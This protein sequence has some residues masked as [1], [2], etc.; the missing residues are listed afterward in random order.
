[1][2]FSYKDINNECNELHSLAE[3]INE[4]IADLRNYNNMLQTSDIWTGEASNHFSKK[5]DR[6]LKNFDQIS[7]EIEN[8]VLFLIN[9]SENYSSVE[10]SIIGEIC[11][12]LN[13]S[14]P[15]LS[16]SKIFS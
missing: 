4:C 15:N 6:V 10:N 16:T 13:I 8:S 14:E 12:N 1:M 3:K 2:K 11:N 9:T 5:M 7:I